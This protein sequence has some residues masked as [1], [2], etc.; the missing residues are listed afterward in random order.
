MYNA[1]CRRCIPLYRQVL[2]NNNNSRIV[3]PTL[4]NPFQSKDVIYA[5]ENNL[6]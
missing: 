6:C 3:K 4:A 2:L 1:S 5:L